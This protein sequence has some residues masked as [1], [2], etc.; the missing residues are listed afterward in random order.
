MSEPKDNLDRLPSREQMEFV[1]TQMR[2]MFA[3]CTQDYLGVRISNQ[4][5]EFREEK[6]ANAR[7]FKEL[8]DEI[9]ALKVENTRL[10]QT[11]KK[12]RAAFKDLKIKVEGTPSADKVTETNQTKA[13]K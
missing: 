1:L 2:E 5:E 13:T 3:F 7:R 10:S 12:A 9:E 6:K 4:I 11:L 8:R